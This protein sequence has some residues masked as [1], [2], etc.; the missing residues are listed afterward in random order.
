MNLSHRICTF[1]GKHG[2]LTTDCLE[3]LSSQFG[4]PIW[5]E[6]YAWCLK[7]TPLTPPSS[8]VYDSD[9]TLQLYLTYF[10]TNLQQTFRRFK[11]YFTFAHTDIPFKSPSFANTRHHFLHWRLLGASNASIFKLIFGQP[12]FR[13]SGLPPP[14]SKFF[15]RTYIS[16]SDAPLV[17]E[18][19]LSEIEKGIITPCPL[20]CVTRIELRNYV[21][22]K[23]TDEKRPIN[24]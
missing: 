5:H 22:K 15:Q 10:H 8:S 11:S 21:E 19:I 24:A 3:N 16:E 23:N 7:L 1:C 6:I 12:S 17:M 14:T 2:H 13:H 4:P 20:V 18:N 9:S